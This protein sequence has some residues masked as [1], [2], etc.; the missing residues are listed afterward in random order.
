MKYDRIQKLACQYVLPLATLVCSMSLPMMAPA[1]V[2]ASIETR[3]VKP[4]AEVVVRR[5]QGNEFKI[6]GM[7]KDGER[8]DFLEQSGSYARIR[9]GD[10][11]GWVLKRYLSEDPPLDQVVLSLQ[12]E[13]D[14]L[15]QANLDMSEKAQLASTELSR[16]QAEL[17]TILVERDQ[18]A[19]DYQNLQNDTAN[20]VQIK[21]DMARISTENEK[22]QQSLTSMSDE[23]RELKKEAAIHWFL[24][25]AGVLLVG[26]LI[27]RLPGP[28]R[29]RKSSL[30]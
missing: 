27:G 16:I 10:K 11:E 28:S 14:E 24:A 17:D 29:R 9:F 20:V 25:G 21:N 4:T 6:I 13:R 12:E 3:Y 23:N 7:V 1:V 2:D 26:I 5:G 30:L 8:V 22:L 19:R 18:L 15:E